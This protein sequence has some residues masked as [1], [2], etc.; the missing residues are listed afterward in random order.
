VAAPNIWRNFKDEF[1]ALARRENELLRDTPGDRLLRAYCSYGEEHPALGHIHVSS[2]PTPR[3]KSEF[4]DIATRAGIVIG[5]PSTA[6]PVEFWIH[7]LCQD[8]IESNSRELFAGSPSGGIIQSLIDSSAS[9]CLRLAT[10]AEEDAHRAGQAIVVGR[11]RTETLSASEPPR[12]AS[13]SDRPDLPELP[14]ILQNAF[15]AAKAAAELD[16]ANLSRQAPHDESQQS[17]LRLNR[18]HVVFFSYCTQARNACRAGDWTPTHVSRSVE[19]AWPLI[20]DHYFAREH[21]KY[22]E[23]ERINFTVAQRKT[24]TNDNRWR[25]HLSD[26]KALAEGVRISSAES[27]GCSGAAQSTS[28]G[29][30]DASTPSVPETR[31]DES[32]FQP[33]IAQAGETGAREVEGSDGSAAPPIRDAYV[34]LLEA[35]VAKM[36]ISIE[37]W[38]G[39]HK[40][41]A[42]STVFEWKSL[43]RAGKSL[44]GRISTDKSDEIELAIQKDAEKLG[45]TRSDSD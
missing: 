24:V 29:L 10:A 30:H 2:G 28:V 36:Q 20:C 35:V 19:I 21:A 8:L 11:G 15:E 39:D 40:H 41:L 34:E 22:S 27:N 45:L 3:I 16:Y 12:S 13:I 1:D 31:Q 17:L 38:V 18:I 43:R 44:K 26:L 6:V 14:P 42:R 33:A 23:E 25:Q 37:T 9:Y 32:D 4:T 5:C 7:C